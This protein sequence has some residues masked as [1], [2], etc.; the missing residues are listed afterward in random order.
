MKVKE[1]VKKNVTMLNKIDNKNI[2]TERILRNKYIK[3]KKIN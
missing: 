2:D 3:L 1:I